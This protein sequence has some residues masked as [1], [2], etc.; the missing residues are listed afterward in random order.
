MW[1]N[2]PNYILSEADDE[3]NEFFK[4]IHRGISS[5]NQANNG[6]LNLN[7]KT[8]IKKKSRKVWNLIVAS[9]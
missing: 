4:Y 7:L 2:N 9:L 6:E 5:V 1:A 8:G 3:A